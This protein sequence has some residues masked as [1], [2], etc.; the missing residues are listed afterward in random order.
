MIKLATLIF[1]KMSLGY[2]LKFPCWVIKSRFKKLK[3]EYWLQELNHKWRLKN[4]N[5]Q[6]YI[7]APF[8]DNNLINIVKVGNFSS[9]IINVNYYKTGDERLEI[10]CFCSIATDAKFIL[11]G[12]HDIR[13]V[14]TSSLIGEHFFS[15]GPILIE[16]DVWIGSGATIMSGVRV[17]KGAVIAAGSLVTKNVEPYSIVAGI[18]AKFI[19]KRFEERICKVLLTLDFSKIRLSDFND[20]KLLLIEHIDD[21]NLLDIVEQLKH[22]IKK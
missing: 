20:V 3:Y 17:G 22:F 8:P 10:G 21:N 18:P 7:K 13:Q 19:K 16:D 2:Y 4:Q 1:N 12:N 14:S 15:K 11:G 6:T 9:G 5:N